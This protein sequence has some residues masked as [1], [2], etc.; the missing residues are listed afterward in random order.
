[1]QNTSLLKPGFQS[2]FIW[3][4]EV[5]FQLKRKMNVWFGKSTRIAHSL[6]IL[7]KDAR[8]L[9]NMANAYITSAS[10]SHKYITRFNLVFY[11]PTYLIVTKGFPWP[12]LVIIERDSFGGTFEWLTVAL[13]REP[14]GTHREANSAVKMHFYTAA[15][16]WHLQ[17]HC[18]RY[19]CN[20][21]SLHIIII[22]IIIV[23]VF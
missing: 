9:V 17:C 14:N 10:D 11:C 23:L 15:R 21:K 16:R 12:Q 22:I 2:S 1:M 6:R 7:L 18:K 13:G 3:N 19:S 4:Y 8:K 20:F 5:L